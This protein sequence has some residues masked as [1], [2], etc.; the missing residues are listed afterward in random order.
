[1][2]KTRTSQKP[3]LTFAEELREQRWDD[4]RYYHQSRINQS[5][6]LVSAFSFLIT[7]VLIFVNPLAA[8]LLGWVVAMWVRQIGHFFFE[9]KGFDKVNQ[10]TFKHK[11]AIKVGFNL[12]RKV[13]LLAAWLAI[14]AVLWLSPTVFG[15]MAHYGGSK[16]YFDRLGYAWLGLAGVGL[17]GRTLFLCATRSMQTGLVWFTKIL[18]EPFHDIKIYYRSPLYLLKGQW[19]DPMDHVI[20][21]APAGNVESGVAPSPSAG[22]LAPPTAT[23][24]A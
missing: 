1:M 11:E 19:F 20:E 4:H 12:R 9:P 17:L 10:A 14:P 6:H 21:Y 8:A 15:L 18:T 5:L 13:I 16:G 22:D 3:P 7:Y 23:R 2:S 24:Q